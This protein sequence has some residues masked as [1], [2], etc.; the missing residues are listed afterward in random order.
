MISVDASAALLANESS[1]SSGEGRPSPRAGHR[2]VG[3][4]MCGRGPTKL[5]IA[6]DN[7]EHDATNEEL[8]VEA[9]FEFLYE[10]GSDD[11]ED[12][13]GSFRMR[14]KSE[15]KT[16]LLVFKPEAWIEEPPGYMMMG[17]R[18]T[19]GRSGD[20]YNGTVEG[21]SCTTFDT[22]LDPASAGH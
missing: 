15:P 2:Y 4:F 19:I 11:D 20:S 6:I 21:P 3:V 17:V 8:L 12:E 9:R 7:V 1:T 22:K 14:G 5:T 10:A 18:G 16:R 13:R